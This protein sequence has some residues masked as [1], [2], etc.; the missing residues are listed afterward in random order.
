[1]SIDQYSA[2][3]ANNDL[4]NYFKTGM[5]PSAVKNAGWD[6]MADIASYLVS[7]PTAGGSAN[8]LTVS[9]GRP[10]GALV[11]GLLQV[12]NPAAANTAATTFA[13]DGLAAKNIFAWGKALA[14]GELQAG[15]PA[16]V[17]Y[18]GTQWNLQNP[19]G[20]SNEVTIFTASGNFTPKITGNYLVVGI[21]GGGGGGGGSGGASSNGGAGGGG[22]SGGAI[23]FSIIPLTAG[24]AY[25]VAIGTGGVGGNNGSGAGAGSSGSFGVA[26]TF[27][28]VAIAGGGAGGAGSPPT[29]SFNG[30]AFGGGNG[31]GYGGGN[32][33]FAVAG[34]GPIG[35]SGL[36]NTGGGGGSGGANAN[37]GGQGGAGGSGILIV[38]R[39]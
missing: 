36:S 20:G 30:R 13:P 23:G 17:K 7:L 28:A 34:I 12:L 2:T 19:A 25:A 15:V 8:V 24:T 32:G 11:P 37:A 22:G 4:T 38:I 10:F 6:V 21:G 27:N 39:A 29:S 35:G 26:T 3:P 31:G 14:G 1:M 9:N 16:V 33:G 18:D 5:R